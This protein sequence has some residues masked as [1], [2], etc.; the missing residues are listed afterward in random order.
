MQFPPVAVGDGVLDNAVE[1]NDC[2][3]TV[4]FKNLTD[5]VSVVG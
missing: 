4:V 3:A 1:D 2:P 5:A